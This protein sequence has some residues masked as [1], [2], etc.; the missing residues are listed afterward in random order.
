MVRVEQFL[1]VTSGA[2]GG[3]AR[4]ER[5]H[6]GTLDVQKWFRQKG[7]RRHRAGAQGCRCAAGNDPRPEAVGKL[8][9]AVATVF[10]SME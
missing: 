7:K 4:A 8:C 5:Q 9:A 10:G 1:A 2:R 6:R 3:R